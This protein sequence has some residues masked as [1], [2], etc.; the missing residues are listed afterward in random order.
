MDR[1]ALILVEARG[2]FFRP[3][4]SGD[5]QPALYNLMQA[6]RLARDLDNRAIEPHIKLVMDM[7]LSP[8]EYSPTGR[9]LADRTDRTVAMG[10]FRER[11]AVVY[12]SAEFLDP[13]QTNSAIYRTILDVR[14]GRDS[15]LS[16]EEVDLARSLVGKPYVKLEIA[17]L[18]QFVLNPDFLV[19][20]LGFQ[21]EQAERV[22]AQT[23]F[24]IYP[25]NNNT[26]FPNP[27]ERDYIDAQVAAMQAHYSGISSSFREMVPSGSERTG[28]KIREGR[29]ELKELLSVIGATDFDG[30]ICFQFPVNRHLTSYFDS[31]LDEGDLVIRRQDKLGLRAEERRIGL[32]ELIRMWEVGSDFVVCY[33][34]G[35]AHQIIDKTAGKN[36][37]VNYVP[38]NRGGPGL[39][40]DPLLKEVYLVAE[41]A[42]PETP[43]WD[44]MHAAVVRQ[45]E[46]IFKGREVTVLS[47]PTN[48]LINPDKEG[49]RANPRDTLKTVWDRLE[50]MEVPGVVI[51]KG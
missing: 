41:R 40:I 42:D 4:G 1:K 26:T 32:K 7:G 48:R 13:I 43:V 10:D 31:R 21:K 51:N 8:E 17:W 5:Y 2:A 44:E 36:T 24:S 18:R 19:G 22:L 23:K 20:C 16:D 29:K 14:N 39:N 27:L 25:N 47:Y 35:L 34:L 38:R 37:L 28:E 6:Y 9:F 45:I 49:R 12:G 50:D 3:E 30:Q 11:H 33:P 46:S 15:D